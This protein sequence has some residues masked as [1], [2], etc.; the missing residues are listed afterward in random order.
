MT[1]ATAHAL[2][3]ADE[4]TETA[5]LVRSLGLADDDT[6]FRRMAVAEGQDAERHIEVW[7][8]RPG[9]AEIDELVVS[10]S[11]GR[12]VSKHTVTGQY[13][14]PGFG[15]LFAAMDAVRTDPGVAEAVA[16]RGITDPSR[17][18]VDPWPTGNMGLSIEDGHRSVR[19]VLFYRDEE[20]D[21]GYSRPVDGLMVFVD[22]DDMEVY[23]IEDIGTWPLADEVS[24]YQAGSVTPRTG[25]RTIDIT[26]PD[27]A[28][29]TVTDGNHVRWQNWDVRVLLDHTEGLVLQSLGW[30]DGERR[31]PILRRASLAEMVVPYGEVRE[32]QAFKNAL[33]VGE[34]GLGRC[35]NS[36]QLG[37]D[38]LGDITYLD[39][40]WCFDDGSP[41][42]I[43]QAICIHEEDF[44][45][46]WKHT[47]MATQI[48][49]V[50]RSR[51]LVIS[52]I[53]TVGN[54]DYGLFWYLYLDGTIQM[55]L[56]LTGIVT[57]MSYTEG[58]DLTYAALVAPE[59]AA[60]IHQHLFCARFDLEV[61]GPVNTVYRVDVETD[62]PGD[63]N[64]HHNAFRAV[65]NRL[66]TEQ[67]AIADVDPAKARTWRIVNEQATN[68]LGQPTGYKLLPADSPTMF[69]RPESRIAG[70]AG[71]AAHNIW[72][73][74]TDRTQRFPAG[75]HVS[76]SRPEG[77]GLPAWTDADRPI[78]GTDI[79]LWHTFGLTHSARPEDY[80][81]MPTEY[82]RC[83]LVP[84]GF[85]D[86]NPALDVP[87]N[88]HC[89]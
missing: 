36:L 54:Y 9:P 50:R 60:P 6:T 73:T 75:N 24:N 32:T 10:L 68:R 33:D 21:N 72:V 28:S 67:Q 19:C 76:Q 23:H 79:T 2:L 77:Q 89:H 30:T 51:R 42:Q 65:A 59:V 80:P 15:E 63:H 14:Q 16:E 17:L 45:I 41:V 4:I 88:E 64:P 29:F 69:A 47:D 39:G 61:D 11:T 37:C 43:D 26:Q 18:Q 70:R 81:V 22:L 56:K 5:A 71:F 27:G 83:T 87:P 58:D 13:P 82:A 34:V 38:C 35:V 86:R 46:G 66:E 8:F 84:F 55:E 62:E 85:F 53:F 48:P 44:G 57:T 12:L 52:S 20:N 1:V 74:P 7:L 31:R 40:A 25:L 49:E 78:A 3:T